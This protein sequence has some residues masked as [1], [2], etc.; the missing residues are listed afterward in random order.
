MSHHLRPYQ[1]ETLDAVRSHYVNGL[2]SVLIVAPTG[3]GK[4]VIAAAITL[5]AKT[6]GTRVLFLAHRKELI[7]QASKKLAAS[8][9]V[10][11]IISAQYGSKYAK[12][13]A[14]VQIAS[15]QTLA[16]R[17]NIDLL[18]FGL[19]IIDEAHHATASQYR[20]IMD[21]CGKAWRLGLTATAYR[22][23]GTGLGDLFDDFHQVATVEQL[24]ENNFL[25]RTRVFAGQKLDLS[26]VRNTAGDYNEKDLDKAINN[27]KLVGNIVHEWMEHGAGRTTVV[28]ACT[29][30]HSQAIV[31]QFVAAG[32]AAEHLDGAMRTEDRS[33]VLKRL[34]TGETTVVSNCAVLTE[35]WDLPQCSCV[36]LARPTQSRGLWKQMV[37]RGMR[38]AKD[39]DD[40]LILDHAGCTHQHGFVE[41]ED[42][43]DLACGLKRIK[44]AKV[45]LCDACGEALRH[46]V[47]ECP[48][49]GA[50]LTAPPEEPE[51]TT[52]AEDGDGPK[53]PEV[54]E[55]QR[56][57]QI[58]RD[59][60]RCGEF[61]R[62]VEV[63]QKRGY[64]P[65]WANRK[66]KDSVGNWP[67]AADQATSPW[68]TAWRKDPVTG[69]RECY[70]SNPDDLF[71]QALER[72]A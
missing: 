60:H 72:S 68:K 44:E 21:R 31:E 51:Q 25:V 66:F 26:G 23:D 6:N 27:A 28:F 64:S 35:G 4:T 19:V 11:G 50:A 69:Q 22:A 17:E 56:L 15:V 43:V 7:E 20:K 54:D 24:Q 70:W 30:A 41:D 9:I 1:L 63:A 67:T 3:A 10:H 42:Q 36:I 57:I 53:L 52:I 65:I 8:G 45:I 48:N 71:A 46:W 12:P 59:E 18:Q 29:V 61:A 2:Q 14:R 33:A 38:P 62:L 5:S 58:K 55:D 40:C 37:G 13:R 16:R 47:P 32:I 34:A 49:C 39:K